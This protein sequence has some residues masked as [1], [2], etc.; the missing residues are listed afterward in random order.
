MRNREYGDKN[1]QQWNWGRERFRKRM[2]GEGDP[3]KE[4]TEERG[5]RQR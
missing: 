2:T 5:R 3:Q 1:I 4:R